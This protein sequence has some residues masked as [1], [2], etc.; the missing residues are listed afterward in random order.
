[1]SWYGPGQENARTRAFPAE[2]DVVV[3]GGGPGGSTFATQLARAGHR[4]VVFE[5]EKFPRFHIGESLLPWNV[6]LFERLGVLA[7]LEASG[8][9]V[10]R[11]ARF[12]HQGSS[13]TRPVLFANG[14][15][16]D[17]PSSFQVKRAE[18]D[19]LLLDHARESGAAVFEESRVTEVLFDAEGR[20]RRA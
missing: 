2:A 12:Y 1:M 9:Q 15:D 14:V 19:A 8:P 11:G 6:P 5:R 4:T 17:H 3:C 18:F 10:K 20:G 7:K 16:R 13:F